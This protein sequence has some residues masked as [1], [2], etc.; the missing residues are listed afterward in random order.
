MLRRLFIPMAQKTSSA[1]SL[2]PPFQTGP[3]VAGLRFGMPPCGR[4]FIF[5]EIST[6]TVH[7]SKTVTPSG[8]AVLFCCGFGSRRLTKPRQDLAAG[9]AFPQKSEP[10]RA[11]ALLSGCHPGPP[12]GSWCAALR[13][14]G[15]LLGV[16]PA[17]LQSS[18]CRRR[19]GFGQ[20]GTMEQRSPSPGGPYAEP[21]GCLQ[22]NK[23]LVTIGILSQ[24]SCLVNENLTRFLFL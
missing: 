23:I 24:V 13:T 10:T 4:H 7:P 22:C 9:A 14:A 1:R 6:L 20:A 15:S 3:A 17:F 18:I 11:A 16:L 2:A 5:G 21:V 19:G 8:V 12:R